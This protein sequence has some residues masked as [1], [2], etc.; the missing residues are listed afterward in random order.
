MNRPDLVG[1]LAAH[2]IKARKDLGQ[3]WLVDPDVVKSIIGEIDRPDEVVEVGPG[4]GVLTP[5]LAG[6]AAHVTAV[7]LDEAM[8]RLLR[9]NTATVSNLDIRQGDVLAIDP[10]TYPAPYEVV[11]NVPYYI[12]SAILR[13]F[14]ETEHGPTRLTLT[15][16]WEVAERITASPP[17]MSVL[18]VSVQLFGRPRIIRKID[19]T[20]FW[21]P[22]EVDSAVIVVED[23]G[24]HT[25][26]TLQGLDSETFFKV[27]KAGF[28]EKRKQ[29]HNTLARHLDIS[30]PEAASL[31][32]GAGVEPAR[33]AETVTVPEWVTIGNAY[34][35]R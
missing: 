19:R 2:G 15:I 4:P 29:L 23:V 1:Q 12:T 6:K 31:L 10:A 13:H 16:Q 25:S 21:P 32:S 27:V 34:A 30:H 9:A 8:I 3:H 11:G 14:L 33:R 5:M 18:A 26:Q 20:S 17:R 7:E 28:A 35:R 22:P 24:V